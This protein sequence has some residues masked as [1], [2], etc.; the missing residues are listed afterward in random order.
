ML[1]LVKDYIINREMKSARK[2]ISKI[3]S[4]ENKTKEDKEKI[5]CLRMQIYR[6][7]SININR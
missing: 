1:N 3:M 7:G 5:M 4:L 2:K 6:L